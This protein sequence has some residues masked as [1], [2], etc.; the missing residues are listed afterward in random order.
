[1][2][3]K[4][5]PVPFGKAC[6]MAVGEQIKGSPE[7]SDVYRHSGQTTSG[8]VVSLL[9]FLCIFQVCQVSAQDCPSILVPTPGQMAVPVTSVI[10]WEAVVGV[11]GYIISIGTTPGGIEIVD[12]QSVGSATSFTPPL[13]LPSDADIYVTIT[14]FFFDFGR[15]DITCPTV[16]FHTAPVLSSPPC[17][18]LVLPK[19][20]SDNVNAASSLSWSYAPTATGYFLSIGTT[21]GGIDLFNDDVGNVLFY[22]PPFDLPPDSDIYVTLRPYNGNGM[23]GQC[24]EESFHTG[25]PA[26]LPG[27]TSLIYPADG[28]IN[29]PLSPVLQWEQVPEATGYE[30]TIGYSPFTGEILDGA[31]FSSTSTIVIDFEAY[32]T[33]FITIVPVNDAGRA[34]GCEQ[35]SFSTGLGCGPFFD[36]VSG[37]LVTLYPVIDFPDTVSFCRNETPLILTANE[38]GDGYRWFRVDELG[39]ETLLSETGSVAIA[40]NGD[41]LLEVYNIIPEFEGQVACSSSKNFSVVTSELATIEAVNVTNQ[42]N[43]LSIEVMVSGSGSYEYALDDAEGPYQEG[44]LFENI[45]PGSHRVY[46]RDRNG[47]GIAQKE[48]QSGLNSEGFPS[49]FTPNGDGVND[50]WQFLE[51]P[52]SS[53]GLVEAIEIYDRFGTLVGQLDPA[54]PGWD[55]TYNGKPLPASDYWYRALDSSARE[56]RGHFALKR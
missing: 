5:A 36:P 3:K 49:F 15:P 34:I 40:D 24:P 39:N 6:I 47:C 33:F 32:R 56:L 38:I 53:T 44:S 37:E 9:L 50:F 52:G 31:R 30:I 23:A 7:P 20:G 42:G 25:E 18:T 13:G 46:V 29:V 45:P 16:F 21:P 27:C 22:N 28:E 12:K 26:T 1:M 8:T 54:T 10:S 41:Y 51:P 14:L 55:G 11:P 35:Q 48:V 19:N 2:K 17:T 43:G 4:A